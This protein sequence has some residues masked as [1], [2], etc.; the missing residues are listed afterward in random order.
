MSNA[1]VFAVIAGVTL[2]TGLTTLYFDHAF[3]T[4][5]DY[6]AAIVWGFGAQAGLGLIAAALD[7]I[8]ASGSAIRP[9][10]TS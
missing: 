10:T 9:S 8:I 3:G 4:W 5:R 6:G 2:W 7:R 1:L